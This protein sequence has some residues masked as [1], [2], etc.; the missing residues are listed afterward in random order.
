MMDATLNRRR[1]LRLGA[2]GL[3][4][5]GAGLLTGTTRATAGTTYDMFRNATGYPSEGNYSDGPE[6]FTYA[7][8]NVRGGLWVH[9][10]AVGSVEN[11]S[12]TDP[13]HRGDWGHN[14]RRV[15]V[16]SRR[17]FSP[18]HAVVIRGRVLWY[19]PLAGQVVGGVTR[20]SNGGMKVLLGHHSNDYNYAVL[21]IRKTGFVTVQREYGHVYT[22]LANVSYPTPLETYRAFKITWYDD[23]IKVYHRVAEDGSDDRLIASTANGAAPGVYDGVSYANKPIGMYLDGAAVRM[24][25]L[26]VWQA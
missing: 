2:G 26:R 3:T 7:A 19:D 17:S 16:R 21:L 13:F 10:G 9:D 6:L 12:Y 4:L 8:T 1:L 25:D 5:A 14:V 18:N 11:G 20:S 15:R 23:T 24:T 22:T